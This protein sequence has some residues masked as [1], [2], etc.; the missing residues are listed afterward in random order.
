MSNLVSTIVFLAVVGGL[1]W[2]GWG[3][4]P[5]WSS[6]DGRKFMCRML[7][8]SAGADDSA[9]GRWH[10][11]KIGVNEDELFVYARSRRSASLRG[12]WKI[13]GVTDDEKKRRRLYEVRA[14]DGAAAVL[15]VPLRSR[16]VPVLDALVP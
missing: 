9:R 10:D 6:K 3:L 12:V 1:A 11:V 14:S 13:S 7:E 16:C 8:H 5:H 4:E 15:R 2:V